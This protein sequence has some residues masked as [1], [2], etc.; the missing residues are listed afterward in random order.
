MFPENLIISKF[1]TLMK[2]Q[3]LRYFLYLLSIFWVAFEYAL[4]HYTSSFVQRYA[5]KVLGGKIE[6]KINMEFLMIKY[7][8]VNKKSKIIYNKDWFGCRVW[9]FHFFV[10]TYTWQ[11]YCDVHRIS[12]ILPFVSTF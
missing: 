1:A 10:L 9:N 11:L 4:E 8:Q 3:I 12:T 2:I 5:P 6:K 7:F